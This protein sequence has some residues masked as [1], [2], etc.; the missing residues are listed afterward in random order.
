[1]NMPLAGVRVVELATVVAAPTTS[2]MLCA[3]G[4]EVVKVETLYGDEMRRAGKTELTPYEDYKNPLFTVHNSNK[5][6]T[7]INFKDP[8]GKAALLKLIGEADVFITNVREASLRRSG[9]D[10]DTLRESFPQ[11]IYAH[12]SGFGPKGPVASNPGFDSTGFWLRS[13]PMADWQVEGSFPFV[14]TYAFGDMATS[15]VLL[16]GILMAL[17]G[18]EKTGSGT[19]VETSLFAS[20][21]WCNSVGV[22]E[23][24]FERR[25]LNP[26]PFRP[27][28]PFDTTYKC[29]D[30]KW[31]GVYVNEYKKDKAKLAKLL[32][33]EDILEDPRYDDIATLA[34]SGVIVE[35]VKRCNEIFLTRTSA[36][37]RELLSANSVSCEVM[38]STC[39]VSRDSQAI[40]NHY[41]EEL[42][43]ADGLKVM[44]PCPPVHFSEYTRR[45]YEPT[46]EIGKDTDAV[47]ASLGYSGE[48][49][50][51]LREKGAIL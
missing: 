9:L 4:A 7:S 5:R 2:R 33:M 50:A 1:M 42:E 21:I 49:I 36:E 8:E 20:G 13:G 16:S 18:R 41:V 6:L 24:Q 43:F 44:M 22:V 38:Q 47:F 11:L 48:E 35:A 31:I 28:D 40:E 29:A 37:W 19:K 39:D 25:H 27:A 26:D 32:G 46:G 17:L 23:T 30:G 12:F 51:R 45:P 14:P 10:Y 15:S 34:E 3:Y